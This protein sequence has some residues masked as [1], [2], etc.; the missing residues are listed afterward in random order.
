MSPSPTSV[1]SLVDLPELIQTIATQRRTGTLMV[2]RA[3]QTRRLYFNNGTLI[4]F[5]GPAPAFFARC[6]TWANLLKPAKLDECLS[7]L[8]STVTELALID[9]AQAKGLISKDVLLDA[10]DCYVE[11]GFTELVRWTG[12]D[13][14]FMPK[15]AADQWAAYQAKVGMAVSPGAVLLE[16]LRRL[17][18]I[19]QIEPH[20]PDRWDVL[21]RDVSVAS[22]E[23]SADA[24][25][26]LADWHDGRVVDELLDQALLTPFRATRALVH[27]RQQGVLRVG[28]PTDLVVQADAANSHG[29][30]EKAYQLYLRAAVL[31]VDNPRVF[32]H[33]AELAE[34]L[35]DN[36]NAA[37]YYVSAAG[38]LSDPGSSVV[39]L[40]NALRLGADREEPLL[41]LYGI[42]QHMGEKD[43]AI[44]ILIELAELHEARKSLDQAAQAV[45]EAQ[46]LGAEPAVCAAI[47][48][49]LALAEGDTDQAVLQF[50]LVARAAEAG[51]RLEE[52]AVALKQL[53]NLRPKRFD[54]V[55]KHAEVL[56][57]LRRTEEAGEALRRVLAFKDEASD[58]V[59]VGVYELLARVNP[60]DLAAHQWLADAY[61]RRKNRDGA[62]EQL[63]LMAIAQERDG[64]QAALAATLERILEVG[65]E[66][67]DVLKRLALVY[68]RLGQ[69]GKATDALSRSVD[70]SLALGHLRE[71]RTMCEGAIELDPSSLPLR[72]RL[73]AVANREGD[74]P[75][76]ITQY[77]AATD[78]ARGR[79]DLDTAREMLLQLR[80]LRP[81]DLSLRL[82]LADLAQ[83]YGDAELGLILRDLVRFAVRTK[84]YGVA[85]ERAR[86]RVELAGTEVVAF[87]PRNELVEL[88]RRM[89][90]HAGEL[91]AGRELLD[92]LLEA[93][94]IDHAVEL[95]QRLVASNPRN[96][97]L[98]IQLAEVCAALGDDR[99]AQRF[100][101]HGVCLLQLEGR[102]DEA[103]K[104]LDLIDGLVNDHEAIA[105]ARDLLAK[106]QALEWEAIRWS[107]EQGQRRR[108]ADEITSSTGSHPA[109]TGVVSK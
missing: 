75:V 26:L 16:A 41:Q 79:G 5:N 72:T 29:K 12:S 34:R 39:A 87:E 74:R 95:L 92:E 11:E 59:L 32:L 36:A 57:A 27:L 14:Q 55:V 63:K 69:D 102:V 93:G 91:K 10:L 68:S 100:Y 67:I 6:L 8:G 90:D 105:M 97:D 83:Q 61:R 81:D 60:G 76:A 7:E 54:H 18:E 20:I 52:A 46:E 89:G 47:L 109:V 21:V 56:A 44:T 53:A 38:L 101:R 15:L 24:K 42:Y 33:V 86:Q 103:N 4:A 99:Q 23:L 17:D 108:I 78:L 107:L 64:N 104:M 31:G 28:S 58:D 13:I 49:R 82:E 73:A 22:P 48:A 45:R 50:E 65:G 106:G 51:G 77:R 66:Q 1:N 94:E 19:K 43:D 25:V 35:G 96:A 62:T 80:K 71:A 40:R 30:H 98:V 85:L 70:A 84:N 37:R 2:Q 3:G 88:L 9:V